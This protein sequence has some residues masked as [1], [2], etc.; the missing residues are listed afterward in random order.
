MSV[1]SATAFGHGQHPPD[2]GDDSNATLPGSK[3]GVQ[4]EDLEGAQ[5]RAPGEGDVMDAQLDK[6]NAGWG[7]QDSL[8]SDLD[9]M[10]QEQA[11][12]REQVKAARKAGL[13]H[14]G[15]GRLENEGNAAA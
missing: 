1:G 9:R 13:V 14:D 7:E 6:K 8:T 2:K 5:M 4:N 11:G 3:V 12:Q 10:K 15:E